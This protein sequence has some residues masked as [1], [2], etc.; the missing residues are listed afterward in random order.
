MDPRCKSAIGLSLIL[1]S[2]LL[3]QN[4]L[5]FSFAR[6]SYCRFNPAT[7]PPGLYSLTSTPVFEDF[8]GDAPIVGTISGLLTWKIFFENILVESSEPVH[9]VVANK[10]ANK[11]STF[12]VEGAA[13]TFLGNYDA[14]DSQYDDIALSTGFADFAYSEEF[15]DERD[16]ESCTYTLTVYPTHQMELAYNT[17]EPWIYAAVVIGVF[18]F[19]AISFFLFDCLVQR[20]QHLLSTTAARQNAIVSS[21]F[22]K[23]IH[24]KLMQEQEEAENNRRALLERLVS[25]TT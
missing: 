21:L 4:V 11:K 22:P 17:N 2:L 16:G 23:K 13:A 24:M 12:L 3:L 7:L 19:T 15:L 9:A 1:R 6:F 25:A 18:I 20:R 14:H 5:Q 8:S 10:C